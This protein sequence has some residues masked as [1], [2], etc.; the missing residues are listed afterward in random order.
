LVGGAVTSGAMAIVGM[1]PDLVLAHDRQLIL[2]KRRQELENIH[3]LR[4]ESQSNLT[5]D[6][7]KAEL[8]D[9]PKAN[10]KSSQ[11]NNKSEEP[12][13]TPQVLKS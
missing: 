4:P 10:D 6:V 9:E 5:L 12:S 11:I 2:D 8:L 1:S 13:I 3:K 7:L